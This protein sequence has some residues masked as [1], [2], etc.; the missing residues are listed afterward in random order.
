MSDSQRTVVRGD[1]VRILCSSRLEDGTCLDEDGDEDR[2]LSIRAG[3][4]IRLQA[5]TNA[6]IGM[7]VGDK[8]VI[9]IPPQEG[10]GHHDP[11]K[12]F[13]ISTRDLPADAR[14]GTRTLIKRNGIASDCL[15]VERSPMTTKLD[16]NHPLAGRT[17]TVSI[18]LLAINQ[19]H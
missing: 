7:R 9:S 15:V 14:V 13:T 1:P 16:A 11:S 5:I 10:F 19:P 6:V 12:V 8:R 3:Q 17:I 2:P 4:P 18:K